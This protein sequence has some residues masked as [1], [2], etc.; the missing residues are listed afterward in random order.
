MPQVDAVDLTAQLTKIDK[1]IELTNQRIRG[2]QLKMGEPGYE[3]KA[4]E[5]VRKGHAEKVRCVP[6]LRA[7]GRSESLIALCFLLPLQL[8]SYMKE[9]DA[10]TAAREQV[11]RLQ[12][13]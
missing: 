4:P 5:A 10:H 13:A 12:T 6:M 9:L 8:A 7:D 2:I 11:I 3:E 1:A